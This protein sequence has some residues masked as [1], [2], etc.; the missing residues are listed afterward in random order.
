MDVKVMN[1]I[2]E[3]S[4]GPNTVAI[5]TVGDKMTW[6]IYPGGPMCVPCTK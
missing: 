1:S 3:R 4:H 6:G 2:H 5:Q